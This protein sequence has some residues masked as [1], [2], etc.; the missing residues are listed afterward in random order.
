MKLTQDQRLFKETLRDYL[1]REI[2]PEVDEMDQ[3]PLSKEQAL[4]YMRD[5]RELGIGYDPDTAEDYFGD[6]MYY[7]IGSEEIARVWPSLNVTLN[8][9]FPA[10][11]ANWASEQTQNA[12]GDKLDKGEL[13]GCM[14]VSEPGSGSDTAR[15]NTT[16]RKEGDEYVLSGEKTWVSNAPIADVALV[17]AHDEEADM[18]DMFI[19]DQE[20]SPF[21]TR[22]LDKLGWKASP[23]GQIFLD[24]VRIPAENKLSTS[25]T[26]MLQQGKDLYE[27]PFADSMVELFLNEKPLNAIFSF[28]RVGMAFMAVGIGQ[29][30][31]DDALAYATDRETFD[32][33]IGQHQLVQ[34][35]LYDIKCAVESSRHMAYHAVELLDDA[36]P[37][38]RLYSSLAKG[39][40]CEQCV[41]A[42]YDAMQVH[43]ANG[44][45]TDYPLERYY[46][47]AR[48]MTVP[49]GTTEIQK[50]I[51]GYEMTDMPAY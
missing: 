29:A 22:K 14:A 35:Q 6:L 31:L 20:T 46:R 16:A 17:V 36:D 47:D 34:E 49:D 13:I 40:A 4:S 1:E 33:P 44:L 2:A 18:Q 9:S 39:Y 43:G 51:V 7:A 15:P 5:L 21:E 38:S 25:I 10:L 23:T 27:L 26:R 11:W 37:E 19:V 32:K 42:T 28:M 41:D 12:V 3:E 8:M 48:T 50:L 45:S 24:D 30:A